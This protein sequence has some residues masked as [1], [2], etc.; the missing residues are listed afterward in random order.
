MRLRGGA[1][2]CSGGTMPPSPRSASPDGRFV[3]VLRWHFGTVSDANYSADGRWIVTA[4]PTTVQLWQPGVQDPLFQPGVGAES[5]TAGAVFDPRRSRV[6]TVGVDG[7]L[8][9]Y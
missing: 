1:C 7:T 5:A 3:Q 8:R 9:T 4:G 2:T 6:L